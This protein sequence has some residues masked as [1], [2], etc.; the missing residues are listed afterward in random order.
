MEQVLLGLSTPMAI[1][2][3]DD[4]IV[5][6]HTFTQQITNLR[7]ALE[8]M[9]IAKLKLSPKKCV[10]FQKEVKYLGHVVNGSG[11]SPDPSKVEA[12][13]NW[14]RPTTATEVKS[15]L[16]L[17]SYYRRFVPSFSDIA[18]HLCQCAATSPFVWS[19]KS[20]EAFQSSH[21]LIQMPCLFLT[22]MRIT[23]ESVLCSLSNM[24]L[25]SRR[26]LLHTG[27][28]FDGTSLLCYPKGTVGSS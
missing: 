9:R 25:I 14:P 17:C 18:D 5:A 13:K 7:R 20:D 2:Y 19:Q 27:I 8:C 12:V 24:L 16:G 23:L 10:L 26:E 1:A 22:Q 15:F 3:L 6:G 11:I 4:I 21:I 28:K